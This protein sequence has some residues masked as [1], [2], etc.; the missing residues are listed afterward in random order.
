MIVATVKALAKFILKGIAILL[1]LLVLLYA[2]FK[3]WEYQTIE[4][5]RAEKVAIQNRQKIKFEDLA[6]DEVSYVPLMVGIPSLEYVQ[7]GNRDFIFSY[8]LAADYK[9]FQDAMEDSAQIIYVGKQILGSG[10]KKQGC[11]EAESAFM[12]DPD[13]GQ[14][15]AAINQAGKVSYY[16]LE[17]GKPIPPAFAKWHGSQTTEAEK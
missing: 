10:C 9:V 7:G 3:V 6:R 11:S 8:L 2:G 12:I 14:Y 16:G 5:D 1:A 13:S 17:E 15:F 4:S